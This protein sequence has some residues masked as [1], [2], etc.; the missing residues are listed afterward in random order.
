[1]NAPRVT[2][3]IPVHNRAHLVGRAIESVLSQSFREF[4][5]LLIDDGSTD[6]S[7]AVIESIGDPR[8]RLLRNEGN[9]GIARTR[10]RGLDEARGTYLAVLDSDDAAAPR[11]LGRQVAFLDAHPEVATVGGWTREFDS[12]DKVRGGIKLLPLVPAELKARLLFRTCHHHSSTMSRLSALR[13]FGYDP[14]FPVSSDYDLFS[15]MAGK[16]QLANLPHVLFYRR[17][18]DGRV[19]RERAAEVRRMNMIVAARQLKA[20]GLPADD[21][22]LSRHISLAR[23][24]KERIAPDRAFL[25][26]AASWFDQIERANRERQIYDPRALESTLG[27]LWAVAC[28]HARKILG[29][30]A[31]S[32][33]MSSPLRAAVPSSLAENLRAALAWR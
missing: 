4:E 13:E 7:V 8:V 20:L 19:T 23:L 33:F 31:L 11:R 3:F 32:I 16:Y 25:E 6:N 5:V 12:S 18:H 14:A 2:V 21:A 17:I 27:Q 9:I 24:K 1:M 10:Q 29:V 28:L 22:T 15:R 26:E 30:S